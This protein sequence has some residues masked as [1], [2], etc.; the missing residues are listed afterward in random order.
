MGLRWVRKGEDR[1]LTPIER[2]VSRIQTPDLIN[3]AEQAMTPIGRHLSAYGRSGEAYDLMEA[4]QAAE[5]LAAITR[6]LQRRVLKL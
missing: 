5:A 3:W 2:R 1:P 6:A 4:A